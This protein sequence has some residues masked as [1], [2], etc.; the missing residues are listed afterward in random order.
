MPKFIPKRIRVELPDRP[1]TVTKPELMS[2]AGDWECVKAAVE[3]GADA[4]YF[5]LD[6]FNARMRANNFTR[7]DLPSLMAYLH[8]RGVKGFLTFNTL[9]FTDELQDATQFLKSIISAG[10]DAAIVQDVGMCRLIRQLSPDFPIH[11]STQMSVSSEAGVLFA[12]ELGA[13]VTVLAR[14]CALNEIA[15]IKEKTLAHGVEMPIEIFVHGA[16]CVAY[17]GQCLTSES[18]GGRSANRGECAQAC[19]LPFE[20]YADGQK[21]PLGDRRYLLSPQDLA[22]IDLIPDIIR[23]GVQ[24]L[25]IEGRLKSAEYVAAVTKVYRK[26]LDNAWEKLALQQ[27]PEAIPEEDRYTLEMTFSRG[28]DTGWMEGINNQRLVH[29][30][31]GKKRGVK[32]GVVDEVT[33]SG[34]WIRASSEIKAGDGVVFDAG[35]PD[36]KE[37]GGRIS[38]IDSHQGSL[39]LEFFND[40]VNLSRVKA[41]QW[42]WKTSDPAL[43]RDLRKTFEVEQPAYHRPIHARVSGKVGA[44][45]ELQLSDESGQSVSVISEQLLVPAESRPLDEIVL[46]KQLGR[47]GSTPYRLEELVIELEGECMFPMSALNQLRRDA[48]E[49]LDVRRKQPLD[50]KLD[51]FH[52]PELKKQDH[53]RS[54]D[55]VYFIP[56]VRS[57]EQFEAILPLQAYR[58]LYLELENPRDYQK[59]VHRF[60]EFNGAR[61]HRTLWVAPPRMFKTGEDWIIE[62]LISSDADGYLVRNHEHLRALQGLRIR[63]DFSLN[64]ANPLAADWL[65][66]RWKLQ[67]LTASYDLNHLQ[68]LALLHH[69]PTDRF[70]ITLHQHMPMF[71]MEHCV[72]CAFL[73]EGKDFRDCGRPC[74]TRQVAIKDRVD[75]LHPLKA[76][77][78]C[79]NTV[80]NAKAQSG[81]EYL[82]DFIDA[83][84]NAFRIEFLNESPEEVIRTLSHYEKLLRREID[85]DSIWRDLKLINQLGV[86]RG[87]LKR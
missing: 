64:V 34:I 48:V 84:V 4:V 20:L 13:S 57:W 58:E 83:G 63:G 74:D 30:R 3:N 65:I 31:F 54:Q 35:N 82:H 56:Y 55:G 47:M 2:P 9:V 27:T 77:A 44:P 46:R 66:E 53:R 85:A 19:R 71:H 41:G 26:A 76:D 52:V 62:K 10:V 17:S 23:S 24:T 28:L 72:F 21:V 70:E 86:T 61:S 32:L 68:L 80:F 69:S 60:R 49:R 14:E 51:V 45:M 25:K 42:L 7:Q 6:R 37:E 67:R 87:T 78:G 50:W 73:T 15:S 81:A 29:A 39:H 11:A 38:K 79:R 8:H 12:H 5:G 1:L 43:D 59:A 22:G 33:R 36:L 18:L 40:T 75:M 16:L